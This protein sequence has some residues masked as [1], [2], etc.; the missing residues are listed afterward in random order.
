[1]I[2]KSRSGVTLF[3]TNDHLE[4]WNGR[5]GSRKL[6]EDVYIWFIEVETPEGKTI[7]KNGTVTIIFNQDTSL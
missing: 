1:M 4:G 5:R 6:P 7:T 2:I 3:Q